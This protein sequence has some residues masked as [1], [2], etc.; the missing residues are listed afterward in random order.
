M[1]PETAITKGLR[2]YG[3]FIDGTDVPTDSS[4]ERRNPATGELVAR[5]AA[6]DEAM[7]D[8]AIAAARREFDRG[9]WPRLSG[10]DRAAA[11]RRLAALLQRDAE[12]LATIEAEEVGK[13]IRLARGDV[14]G[15]IALTEY[16]ASLALTQHGAVYS[17]LGEDFTGLVTREP[18]GVVG[19][20]TPWNFPLLLLMQKLPFALAAGCTAVC[21]PSEIT[22][23]TTLEVAR[24]AIEAGI[25]AGVFN[26]VT[27]RG[28]VVGERIAASFEV[29]MLSFTGST[30]VGAAITR[31][32]AASCKRL[33]MEL[34]GKAASIV[35][36]DAD[37]EDAVDGVLKGVLF[38]NGECCVSG[39]RL[40]VHE[41]VA[42]DFLRA[43][44]RRVA[45]IR[46]G[47][48]LDEAA[49]VGAMIHE[50]HLEQVL[51][52]IDGAVADGAQIVSG[53][54]RLTDGALG[55]GYF[56][57][58]TI[59]DRVRPASALFTEE[60]FGPVLAVTRFATLAEAVELANAVDFGLANSVW[61]KNIDTA[62]QVSRRLRSGT[63][64]VNTTID[65]A[66]Q[67]PGGGVKR[68]GYG[69]EMG[70]AG[71][72]E[73]T[74]VKTIQIRTGKRDPFFVQ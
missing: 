33:S 32:S 57:A 4:S 67:L 8:R 65:G 68:S 28:S 50:D 48:P 40:L 59:I 60:V 63:V 44:A 27:G 69:R 26:V 15:S 53:G 31:A 14:A 41:D 54:N 43:L 51:R 21:K 34:G 42:E 37:L 29:D 24:L 72:E 45:E 10:A 39:A 55:D 71:F 13:P 47:T 1:P 38:N 25:P 52:Y 49:D 5:F 6:G 58:P 20:I 64:W 22:S 30:A 19:M 17:N 62:L 56:V 16:A 35:F 23:G 73:F 9:P 2:T 11:L 7:T 12:L 3:A 18:C 74:E 46:V 61:S 70:A 36:P 66:P